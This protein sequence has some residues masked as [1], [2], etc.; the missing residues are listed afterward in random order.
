VL[1]VLTGGEPR[2]TEWGLLV[3]SCK[4]AMLVRYLFLACTQYVA[5]SSTLVL[6]AVN[7]RYSICCY[8]QQL[9]LF[10]TQVFVELVLFFLCGLLTAF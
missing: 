7:W 9:L 5:A 3:V 10:I 6:T 2:V 8:F 4:V 1:A